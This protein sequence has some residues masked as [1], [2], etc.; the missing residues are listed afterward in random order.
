MTSQSSQTALVESGKDSAASLTFVLI[1][2]ARNEAEF[3]EE[4]IQAMVAQTVRPVRWVIVSDGSTDG[5]DEIVN[6][7]T[8]SH[9]WIELVRLSDHR[10]R[11]FS[12]K[13][14][15]FNAG[16][17]RLQGVDYDVIGNLDADI[18][19]DETY[20]EFL[21]SKFRDNPTLGV[22]GTPFREGTQ[23]YD[24]RFTSIEHV[25]G[26]CQLFRR[27]CYEQI[28]GY[29]PS[30]TGGIDLIA[31]ISARMKGWQ[32]RTFPEKSCLHHRSMGT[33]KQ[34]ELMV[35]Y[36]GG[37]GDYMLGTH[38]LWELVRT[39]Y[40]MTRRPLILGGCL[41]LIGFSWALITRTEKAVAADFV[42]FRR[43]EQMRRLRDFSARTVRLRD[44]RHKVTRKLQRV[45]WVYLT[46][47]FIIRTLADVRASAPAKPCS[48]I[49]ITLE[50]YFRVRDFRD[51]NRVTEYREKLAHKEVGFFAECAGKMVGSIWATVNETPRP[52]VVRAYMRLMP[53]E[54]LIHDIVT[55]EN[56]RGMG[57]GPFMVGRIAAILLNE[58]R[59]SR[60]IIDVNS[61]NVPSLRMME[62][63]GL[64]VK[65][66]M[67]YISAFGRLVL[68]RA[69]SR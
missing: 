26:A 10:E 36:R 17:A 57:V 46:K 45:F 9:D 34:S 31:V 58:Y 14:S 11:S 52:A 61:R 19:F 65:E 6:R 23:Q 21:L 53:R 38:P 50:N 56:F 48:L 20:L 25:S 33:A 47:N 12:G 2:P 7:Y 40:Q 8:A 64:K 41:R 44:L 27:E 42:K 37:K 68:Q 39:P 24:Y 55:G 18:T 16:Y 66:Q 13:V 5:T 54:A 28:G 51:E 69:V 32:T 49:P 15:A 63:A 67:L 29:R 22:A 35:A 43:M 3:I 60:I 30:K 62:K 4:T 59:V 1:T